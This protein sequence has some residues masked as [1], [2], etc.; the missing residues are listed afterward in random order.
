MTP[1]MSALPDPITDLFGRSLA[2]L[3]I[4][5]T[6]RCNL[7]CHYCM[8]EREY[9]WLP[10]K[11]RLGFEE[12]SRLVGVFAPLGVRKLRLT[13]GE[14]LLR[15][16]LP[17][18]VAQLAAI[19]G[20]EEIAMT[21]NGILLPDAAEDLKRAGLNRITVSLD[22]LQPERF[23]TLAGQDRLAATLEGLASAQAAG[24]APIKINTVITRGS[25]DDEIEDLVAF[26]IEGG[27][28]LRFIEYMD[29]GGALDWEQSKVVSKAELLERITA[30]FGA[31]Q[32]LAT[33]ASA[34]ARRFTLPGGSVFGIIASTTEPFCGACTRSRI[35]ADGLLFTCLYGTEGLDLRGLLRQG[36]S[37]G[38]LRAALTGAW[39]QR[40]DR[41]AEERL[42]DP[43]RGVSIPR[44]DL[45]QDPHL[46]MHTKGG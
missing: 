44:D 31:P 8:P 4:S 29:V 1:T 13:G 25:N 16:D 20:I 5:V 24:F 30:R 14:P 11:D 39:T 19:R 37:D 33:E 10:K 27:H 40:K 6:D 15:R 7:R 9:D 42:A 34:P 18:L 23:R 38:E 46:E 41:S 21:T 35:T 45:R 43:R 28:E 2:N 12:L 22:T 32:P 36:A 26:A 17:V 3:R